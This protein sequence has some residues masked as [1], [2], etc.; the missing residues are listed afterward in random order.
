MRTRRWASGCCSTWKPLSHS[1]TFLSTWDKWWKSNQPPSSTQGS[2]SSFKQIAEQNLNYS[3]ITLAFRCHIKIHDSRDGRQV[4]SF[5]QLRNIFPQEDTFIISDRPM[6]P[7]GVASASN[8]AWNEDD[9]DDEIFEEKPAKSSL[10]RS[11]LFPLIPGPGNLA[12]IQIS[13]LGQIGNHGFAL[14]TNHVP[15]EN[16]IRLRPFLISIL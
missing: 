2:I 6:L 10:F 14:S 9:Y 16:R 8:Q 1:K 7:D 3:K 12:S 11:A 5:S 13:M 15:S 4:R